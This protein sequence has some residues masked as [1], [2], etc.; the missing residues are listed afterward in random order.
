MSYKIIMSY[1]IS[2]SVPEAQARHY[3]HQASQKSFYGLTR[4]WLIFVFK[5]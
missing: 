2:E 5:K 3:L 4:L 1:K